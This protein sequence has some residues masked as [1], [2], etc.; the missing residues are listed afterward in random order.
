M[1]AQVHQL[2]EQYYAWLKEKTFLREIENWVEITTP[3]LDRH[4]DYLQIYAKQSNGGF[5][6]TD[7]GYTINDLELSGCNLDSPRRQNQL[8]TTLRGFGVKKENESKALHISATN[9]DFA[10]RKHNLIQAML[11]VNDLF[12]LTPSHITSFFFEDIESWLESLS[13]RFTPKVKF[14]GISGFDHL[15]DFVIPKSTN[16]PERVLLS[17]NRPD[18][19]NVERT[20]FAWEDTK[21]ARSGE[22]GAY[23]ILNDTEHSVSESALSALRVYRVKPVLWT[24]REKVREELVA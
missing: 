17:I 13:I 16:Q 24:D 11:A 22:T 18:R 3:F 8:A 7:D 2:K 5:I 21:D 15:F 4:N 9:E 23:V 20:V 14:T 6:L 12:Y 19:I 10:L 1:I